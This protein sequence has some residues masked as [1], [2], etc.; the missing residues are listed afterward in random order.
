MSTPSR[1]D[2]FLSHASPDKPW[3]ATLHAEL[4]KRGLA[5]YL[6]VREL[7]AGDNEPTGKTNNIHTQHPAMTPTSVFI[8]STS[9]DLQ[10]YR[11]AVRRAGD[12]LSLGVVDMKDFEAADL[13]AV[14]A[15]LGK[16]NQAA[17]STSASSPCVTASCRPARI[18]PRR[19]TSWDERRRWRR[20]GPT[21]SRAC[22]SATCAVGTA[23]ARR[24]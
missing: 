15:S 4:A 5:C 16:L 7:K 24:N 11:A 17:V 19:P 23:L 3:V 12:E 9:V 1:H 22:A 14:R 8:S 18:A 13:D 6:D 2:A 20:C 21:S 10:A